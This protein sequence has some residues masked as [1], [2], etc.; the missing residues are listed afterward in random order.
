MQ[1]TLRRENQKGYRGYRLK[2]VAVLEVNWSRYL[3]GS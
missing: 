1:L 2:R 3:H